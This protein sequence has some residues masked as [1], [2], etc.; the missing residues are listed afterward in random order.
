MADYDFKIEDLKKE[1]MGDTAI[2]TFVI[3]VTGIVVDEYSF[4][5]TA[6]NNKARAKVVLHKDKIGRWR[7]STN[8][9][10]NLLVNRAILPD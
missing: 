10:Q 1:V 9:C 7:W 6:I 5:G 2:A 4:G 3:Q 8:I